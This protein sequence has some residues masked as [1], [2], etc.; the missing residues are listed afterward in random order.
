MI[1]AKNAAK[2]YVKKTPQRVLF[3]EE[4]FTSFSVTGEKFINPLI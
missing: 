2:E 1:M 3:S 4:K